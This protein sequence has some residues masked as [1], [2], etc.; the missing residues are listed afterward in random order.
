MKYTNNFNKLGLPD[1]FRFGI[2]LEANN[3]R[4]KGK[5]GLYTGE[6]AKYIESKKWHMASASEESLVSKGGAELVSPILYDSEQ[7]WESIA[8]MCEHIKKYPGKNG[9]EVVADSNCGLHIHFDAGVLTK[10]PSTMRN[11]L[12]LY[13]ESEE[14]LYKMCNDKNDPIRKGAINKEF[15]GLHLISAMWR[16]GMAAPT[17]KKILKQI[18]NG[19]LK[20]S[21]KKFGK[22]RNIAGKYKLDERRYSGLNLTNIGNSKKNTIEFR[23]ANGTLNP[24]VIKQNVFLYASLIDTAIKMT[25]HP[26][27]Y[28]EKLEAFYK[29]DITEKQKAENFLNLIIENAED[30]QIYMDRWETVKD[31]TVFKKSDKKGFAQKRFKREQFKQIASRTPSDV[32]HSTYLHIKDMLSKTKDKGD[33]EYDR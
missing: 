30:R 21:Y 19:T 7:D 15:K 31:A 20:V 6:S 5:N 28:E 29:T 25:E 14:L 33:S 3:V 4:T 24:N 16:N 11:F 13:A 18:Q 8:D 26:D 17:G 1:G 23:M 2:E 12:R 22:L 32:V 10:N 27:L 9:N